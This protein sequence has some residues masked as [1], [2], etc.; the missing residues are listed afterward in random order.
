MNVVGSTVGRIV[1]PPALPPGFALFYTT[2]DLSGR[3]DDGT[4][5]DLMGVVRHHFGIEATLT[6]CTQVHGASVCRAEPGNTWQECSS[7]DALWSSDAHT[8]LGIKVADCLPVTMIDPAHSVIANVHAGWRGVVQ[9]IT[10]ETLADVDRETAFDPRTSL[11]YLGPSI[12]GCCFEVGEEV[13]EQLAHT[14]GNIA[15][16][17]DRTRAKPHV[18]LVALTVDVL[19]VAGLAEE[20]IHDSGLCTRCEGSMFHSYRRDAK[21]GGRNLALVA[22]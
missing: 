20:A 4:V 13:V 19:R 8:A 7:C 1:V 17:V 11:A 5:S 10:S 6:T 2:R 21:G 3:L 15:P 14:Y 18:D 9:R 16:Y 12:R 22:Q